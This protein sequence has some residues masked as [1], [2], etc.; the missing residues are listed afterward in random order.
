MALPMDAKVPQLIPID[1]QGLL[2]KPA[3]TL[4]PSRPVT[5]QYSRTNLPQFME[6]RQEV[7]PGLFGR[8]GLLGIAPQ[9]ERIQATMPQDYAQEYAD[10]ERAFQ[11][12]YASRPEY[13]GRD[14]SIGQFMPGIP[15]LDVEPIGPD[16]G[17]LA[18]QATGLAAAKELGVFDEIFQPAD[19]V[20][21]F[22]KEQIIESQPV[23]FVEDVTQAGLSKAKETAQDIYQSQ[24]IQELRTGVE[25]I[26]DIAAYPITSFADAVENITPDG[27]GSSIQ[28]AKDK[29]V[30]TVQDLFGVEEFE[31]PKF[32]ETAK[33]L[34]SGAS[35]IVG[36]IGSIQNAIENP[37]SLNMSSALDATESIYNKFSKDAANI[38]SGAKDFLESTGGA[39]HLASFAQNPTAK[40][41]PSAYASASNILGNIMP[42]ISS[43]L[44]GEAIKAS[45]PGSQYI[46]PASQIY[47]GIKALEGGIDSPADV[48]SVASGITGASSLA[49]SLGVG[50]AGVQALGSL[51][52]PAAIAALALQVPALL[53]GGAA[54]EFPRFESTIGLTN[55]N[56]DVVDSSQY[57]QGTD[58]YTGGQT[59]NALD[60]VNYMVD[61]LGYEVD[62]EGYKQFQ[63]SDADTIVDEYGYFTER[64][65]MKDPSHNAADFVANMLRFGAIKPTENTPLDFNINEAIEILDP[66]VSAYSPE[67]QQF[68][69]RNTDVGY[70]LGE[71]YGRPAT[72]TYKVPTQEELAA[73]NLPS[74]TG[75]NMDFINSLLGSGTQEDLTTRRIESMAFDP[76]GLESFKAINI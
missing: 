44:G 56:F 76:F 19:D 28:E 27:V 54:G 29:L 64:H 37:T 12:S 46:G 8:V 63:E 40:G 62:Q 50:G 4:T 38:P 35:D 1:L 55:G 59:K 3:P 43:P 20:R 48:A 32:F 72:P 14:Y 25:N 15:Q 11:E 60:F 18:A 13:F 74:F 75:V 61:N 10:L 71:M 16:Y 36:D 73:L 22:V 58:F 17:Q 45:L 7:S 9:V 30:N 66:D 65:D 47:S 33:D 23:Q 34:F 68:A 69:S 67:E 57:D 52:G 51:A 24:P 70:I 42:E 26:A 5:T 31:M 49:S 53:E 41:L 2:G 6:G 21:D 39:L